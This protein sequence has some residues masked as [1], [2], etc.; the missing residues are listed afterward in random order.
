MLKESQIN[1]LKGE[2]GNDEVRMRETIDYD[3]KRAA[4]RV[5]H[6]VQTRPRRKKP[7]LILLLF[8]LSNRQN[9]LVARSVGACYNVLDRA[10]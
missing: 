10:G 8:L 7:P 2:V 5:Q 1:R 6:C 3:L 9:I 4:G